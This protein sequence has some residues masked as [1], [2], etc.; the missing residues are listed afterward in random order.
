MG[1]VLLKLDNVKKSFGKYKVVKDVSLDIESGEVFGIIGA[2]GSGKTT[3]LNM[4]V[5]FLPQTSGDVVFKAP[6]LLSYD[7]DN[8]EINKF[9]SVIKNQDEVK[10][11]VGFA[12]QEPSFYGKLTLLENLDLF[13]T[14]YGLSKD[15]KR[16]N[17]LILLKLMGLFEFRNKLARNL[18]G[19]MQKRLDIACALIHDPKVLILDE[20]TADLDPHLRSQMWNLIKK[21]NSK[22]TTIIL[23]SHFLDE[24]EDLCDRIGILYDGILQHIGS[25]AELKRLISA[26]EE[27]HIETLKGDYDKLM[28]GFKPHS[29]YHVKEIENKGSEIELKTSNPHIVIERLLK[30]LDKQRDVL[31][32][33]HVSRPTL[34]EVF[35]SVIIREEKVREVALEKA[36]KVAADKASH[37]FFGKVKKENKKKGKKKK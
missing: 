27:V 14:L 2:S 29:K 31:I 20:P 33:L 35:E 6:H 7:S 12:S 13:G 19:G 18:S 10:K 37:S 9:R 4:L 30:I 26:H 16:T 25:P 28:E 23:S 24:L 15:A 32:D 5:G 34:N 36:K 8:A 17:A 11:M 21:I 22:G 3:L 1:E